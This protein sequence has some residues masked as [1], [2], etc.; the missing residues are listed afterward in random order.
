ME[1]NKK[2]THISIA[3]DLHLNTA[4]YFNISLFVVRG[5]GIAAA[6]HF[7]DLHYDEHLDGCANVPEK[8][9]SLLLQPQP[10]SVFLVP[11]GGSCAFCCP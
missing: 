1:Q 2:E 11:L 3:I 7:H 9:A 8:S 6:L 10:P 5:D 4:Y